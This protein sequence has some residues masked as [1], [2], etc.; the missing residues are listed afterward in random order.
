[1]HGLITA[2]DAIVTRSDNPISETKI[3]THFVC[4][5][6]K[7]ETRDFILA[8]KSLAPFTK[9]Y[10]VIS[11]KDFVSISVIPTA[12]VLGCKRRTSAPTRREANE[13]KEDIR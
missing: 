7:D 5:R 9:A 4:I 2:L 6:S 11:R 12:Q 1:M 3:S 10:F 13:P 8:K